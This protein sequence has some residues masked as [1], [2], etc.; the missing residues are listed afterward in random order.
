MDCNKSQW[1]HLA[2]S[3]VSDLVSVPDDVDVVAR[4]Q[5]YSRIVLLQLEK[6][7]VSLDGRAEEDLVS[8]VR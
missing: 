6:L 2:L 3:A 4:H 5:E 7:A 1:N 8:V